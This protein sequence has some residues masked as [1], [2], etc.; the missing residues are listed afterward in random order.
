MNCEDFLRQFR[1]ALD[2]KVS[3]S[4][5]QDNV[6]YYRAYIDSQTVGGRSESD[7]LRMFGDP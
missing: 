4:V 3:E 1:D 5:I 2:G 7:V 6:N